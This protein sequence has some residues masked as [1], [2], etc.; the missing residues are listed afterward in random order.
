[1]RNWPLARSITAAI[2]AVA[3]AAVGVVTNLV[4]ASWSWVLAVA[5]VGL[6]LAGA[7]LAALS[8]GGTNS[9]AGRTVVTQ[10]A[11]GGAIVGSVVEAADG[12]TVAERVGRRGE[13]QDV[14]TTAKNAE[15][16]RAARKGKIRGGKISAE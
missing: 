11:R 14:H 5:L 12:A 3:A 13:I 1:M 15:V 6:V 7:V 16:R 2:G 10:D 8:A 4:T 9:V